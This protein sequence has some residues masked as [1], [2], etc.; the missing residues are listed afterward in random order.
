MKIK[1]CKTPSLVRSPYCI[2]FVLNLT[3]VIS[4]KQTLETH[5]DSQNQLIP[6][7]S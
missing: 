4:I 1:A 6:L 7:I 5:F 2:N 3:I